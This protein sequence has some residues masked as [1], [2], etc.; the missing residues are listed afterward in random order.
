MRK[1][2]QRG[3]HLTKQTAE[4]LQQ[5]GFV[6]PNFGKHRSRQEREQPHE[7]L[8]TISNGHILEGFAASRWANT[9][10]TKMRRS[11]C[12][13]LQRPALHVN[14]R[15]LPSG[16]HHFEHV[17]SRVARCQMKIVIVLARQRT[18][19]GFQPKNFM[20]QPRGFAFGERLGY[21]CL[22]QH[23]SNLIASGMW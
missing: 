17:S 22:R 5:P 18:S 4:A 3:V 2:L 15:P 8:G 7:A 10:H 12:Q 19:A 13:V 16:M 11:A 21:A 1:I 9:R 23:G 6:R 20:R 14:E